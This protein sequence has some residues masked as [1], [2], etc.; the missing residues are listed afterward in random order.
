MAVPVCPEVARS[1]TGS[2]WVSLEPISRLTIDFS[3]GRPHASRMRRSARKWS[4]LPARVHQCN[5]GAREEKGLENGRRWS[6]GKTEFYLIGRNSVIIECPS[7]IASF[8]RE[9]DLASRKPVLTQAHKG[10]RSRSRQQRYKSVT[11]EC[12]VWHHREQF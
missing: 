1:K 3:T 5:S 12:D 8:L 2:H 6:A 10:G 4:F 7:T 9:P 11:R